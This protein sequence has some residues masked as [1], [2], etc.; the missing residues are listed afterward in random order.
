MIKA[1]IFDLYGTLVRRD[2]GAKGE[3][4]DEVLSQILRQANH[5]VYYQEVEAARHMVFFI[6]YPR[7]RADTPR[8][9]YT[10]LL[11]RLEIPFDIR[12]VDKLARKATELEKVRLYDDAAP[13]ASAL[14]SRGIKTAVLTTTPLW[15]FMA[16]LRAHDVKVDIICTAKE[17]RAVKPNPQIYRT[18]LRKLGVKPDE[19]LMVGDTPGI[20]VVPSKKLGMKTVLLC[21]EETKEVKEADHIITSLDQVLNLV[22]EK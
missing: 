20:D 9:F 1:V 22:G 14:K 5:E 8:Q 11:E 16:A 12:L 10:R 19:A 17:A 21:R 6:D 18:V 7:G 3:N 13:T 15:L 2:A 4:L